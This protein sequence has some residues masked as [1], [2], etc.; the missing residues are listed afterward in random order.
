VAVRGHRLGAGLRRPATRLGARVEDVASA[1]CIEPESARKKIAA[2]QDRAYEWQRVVEP[3]VVVVPW[4]EGMTGY[5]LDGAR[6][7]DR[8]ADPEADDARLAAL[9][10]DWDGWEDQQQVALER[11]Y[12]A[13]RSSAD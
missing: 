4:V 2:G 8:P 1:W 5:E 13:I 9:L 7:A 11:A 12:A 6:V 10:P 3:E